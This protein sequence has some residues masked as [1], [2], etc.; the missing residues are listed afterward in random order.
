MGEYI[1]K[2]PEGVRFTK[3]GPVRH[4]TEFDFTV[5]ISGISCFFDA[6]CES[7]KDTF[8]FKARLLAKEKKHQWEALQWAH[9]V[10]SVAG[11]LI[12]FQGVGIYTWASVTNIRKL[13]DDEVKSI[14]PGM[15]G[16]PTASD[17]NPINLRSLM[18]EDLLKCQEK[19]AS[20][21]F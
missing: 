2:I 10:G 9:D 19:I 1:I 5:S 20:K 15:D 17:D 12:W 18:R 3:K 11:L 21:S 14:Q 16:L 6:K 13:L 4:K 7:A 8:N